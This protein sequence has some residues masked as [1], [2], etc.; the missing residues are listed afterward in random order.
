MRIVS[1]TAGAAGMFCGSCLHDNT[2]ASALIELGHDTLLL[3]TYTPIRTD[4]PDVSRGPIFFGGISV[5]LRQKSRIARRLPA[6]LWRP[7]DSR[8]LLRLVS[9]RAVRIRAEELG[10]LTVAMLEGSHGPHRAEI[11]RLV[12]YLDREGK[13]DVI[14][15]TNVLLSGMIPELK[16]RLNV[17]IVATLQGDD[18]FLDALPESF[19]LQSM[20]WIQRNCASVDA[21]IATC[22]YYADYM[23][24]FLGL[25]RDRFHVVY[26]GIHA[27]KFRPKGGDGDPEDRPKD[28][29][30]GYLAR[31]AP[32]KG[33][34]ILAD[35]F[36]RLRQRRPGLKARLH[37]TGWLG[38]HNR[39]YWEEVWRNLSRAGLA[40]DVHRFETPDHESKVKFLH[41]VDVFSVPAPY[42]EP[43]GLYLLEAWAAGC[44]VV[45]PAHGSFPELIEQTRGGV[46]FTPGDV[47]ALAESLAILSE[48]APRRR[49]LGELGQ[50][51]VRERFT[52]QRM[53][54]DTLNVFEH[55][56]SGA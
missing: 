31:I 1:I 13:P 24:S 29:V 20:T 33:L 53:A 30:I 32:E 21:Y 27:E 35:A 56:L 36:I 9:Q 42:R 17:P 23:S 5:Y 3:P 7:L 40:K 4:E 45:Q 25:P 10:Q 18:I 19:R 16:S 37:I 26:P 2:L 46:L 52:A 22:R 38:E 48:E 55:V 8:W 54:R 12:A 47:D 41:A 11:D 28:P 14:L 49:Q 43:K 39:P 15:L 6:W 50:H 51:A 44:P 34:H